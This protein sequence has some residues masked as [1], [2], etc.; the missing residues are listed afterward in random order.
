LKTN[1]G[2]SV[3]KSETLRAWNSGCC[4]LHDAVEIT[5]LLKKEGFGGFSRGSSTERAHHPAERRMLPVL[6]FDPAIEAAG[7]V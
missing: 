1:L 6:D 3:C 2:Q 7:A 4:S 5:P